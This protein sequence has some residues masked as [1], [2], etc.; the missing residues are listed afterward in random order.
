VC[1]LLEAVQPHP[2]RRL[3]LPCPG[4]PALLAAP[5]RPARGD[6]RAGEPVQRRLHDHAGGVPYMREGDVADED[7]DDKGPYCGGAGCHC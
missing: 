2:T 7:T 4:V 1:P 5:V 3:L 6:N